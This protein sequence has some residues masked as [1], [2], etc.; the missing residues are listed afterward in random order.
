MTSRSKLVF[1]LMLSGVFVAASDLTV[2]STILPRIIYDL[3]IP[4]QTSLPQA[5]W[6]VN[7]YL[8]AYT[9]TLP[10]MGRASDLYGRRNTFFACLALF[11]VGSVG[12][13]LADSL[14]WLIVGRVI[15]AL[16]AGAMVPVTMA[17]AADHFSLARQP[18]VLGLIGA[19]DTAGWVIGP[20]YGA[21]VVTRFDW[22][23]LFYVN[24]PISVVLAVFL[25]L[26]MGQREAPATSKLSAGSLKAAVFLNHI[27]WC[28]TLTL[29]VALVLLNVALSGVQQ[30]GDFA[31][32]SAQTGLNP[33]AGPLT[34][35]A[36]ISLCI[37]IL[38][39]RRVERPLINPTLFTR[40]SFNAACLCNFLVG[41][42][43]MIAMVDVP[44]FVNL[45]VA[46]D[47]ADAALKSGLALGAF[48]L[49]MVCGSLSGGIVV[50]KSNFRIPSWIG[51]VIAAMGFWLMSHW[52]AGAAISD[53]MPALALCGYGFGMVI[54]PLSS[55]VINSAGEDNRGIAS[56]V[57][58]V[59]RLVGMALGLAALTTW[60]IGRM[61]E[62]AVAITNGAVVDPTQAAD[63]MAQQAI[64]LSV[65]VINEIFTISTLICLIAC[66]PVFLIGAKPNMRSLP[67]WFGWR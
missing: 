29:T 52:Q 3:E 26:L 66:L 8:I 57:V 1:T 10:I 50:T 4:I 54:S 32:F 16:G 65:Q 47:M 41:G 45:A 13:A 44:L 48:T 37:F 55:A 33:L 27:D 42:V 15:Q 6:I 22:R 25:W 20:L 63:V 18:F 46:S 30:E 67:A 23:L 58:I 40:R 56:A 49:G 60:G 39:E 34:I 61:N 28:G 9:V 31:S 35:F 14:E 12:T 53:M 51:L 21:L 36:M 19:L 24:V 7:A 11:C 59:V 62:L 64:A 5:A 2:V 17:Y 38:N 43:L